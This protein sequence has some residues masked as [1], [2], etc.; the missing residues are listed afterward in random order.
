MEESSDQPVRQ[1]LGLTGCTTWLCTPT[2]TVVLDLLSDLVT[3][4]ETLSTV[5]SIRLPVKSEPS[6]N[7]KGHFRN[8]VEK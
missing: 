8:E 2:E 6:R 5:W 4:F 1:S 3:V 7:L